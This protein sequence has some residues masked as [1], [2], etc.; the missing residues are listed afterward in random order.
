MPWVYVLRGSSG[1]HYIGSA[2]DLQARFAQHLRGHTATTKRLGE[3]LEIV[4]K[5][6]VPTL[7]EARQLERLLKRKKNPKLAIYHLEQ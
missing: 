5:K 3:A 6:E 2:V 7:A 1:R 4:A